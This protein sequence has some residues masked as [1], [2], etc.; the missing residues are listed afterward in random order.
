M[1]TFRRKV[2]PLLLIV[3]LAVTLMPNGIFAK[4]EDNAAVVEG[5]AAGAE[6]TE[7]KETGEAQTETPAETPVETSAETPAETPVEAAS[8]TP[9]EEKQVTP[10]AETPTETLTET[11][12]ETVTPAAETATETLTEETATEK[13]QTTTLTVQSVG[14][15]NGS[16]SN[17]VMYVDHVDIAKDDTANSVAVPNSAAVTVTLADGSTVNLSRTGTST[18]GHGNAQWRYTFSSGSGWYIANTTDTNAKRIVKVKVTYTVGTQGYTY[19]IDSYTGLLAGYTDCPGTAYATSNKGLDIAV[20]GSKNVDYYFYKVVYQYYKDGALEATDDTGTVSQVTATSVTLT[21][22]ASKVRQ[23]LTYTLTSAAAVYT[24]ISLTASKNDAA[25]FITITLKYSYTT[26]V[27]IDQTTY[28]VR[29]YLA[30]TGISAYEFEDTWA[31][32]NTLDTYAYLASDGVSSGTLIDANHTIPTAGAT[33]DAEVKA[34]LSTNKVGDLGTLETVKA[35][36]TALRTAGKITDATIVGKDSANNNITLGEF[37]DAADGVFSIAYVNV[38]NNGDILTTWK[39]GNKNTAGNYQL[40]YHVHAKIVRNTVDD[41]PAA[42]SFTILK[43]DA[44]GAAI[45]S[46]QAVFTLTKLNAQGAATTDVRTFTTSTTDGKVLVTL[47]SEAASYSLQETTAPAGYLVNSTV[48]KVTVTKGQVTV[49]LNQS[50]GLFHS[51]YSWIVNVLTGTPEADA[52]SGGVLTV[53]DAAKPQNNN[54]SITINKT[55][56]G[57]KGNKPTIS[58][59]ISDGTHTY[60]NYVTY[61]AADPAKASVTFNN[62]PAGTYTITE[63]YAEIT[64]YTLSTTGIPENGVTLTSTEG[65]TGYNVSSATVNVTNTYTYATDVK[66]LEFQKV[67]D[68]DSNRDG[69]RPYAIVVSGSVIAGNTETN[70]RLKA[71]AVSTAIP[72]ESQTFLTDYSTNSKVYGYKYDSILYQAGDIVLGEIGYYATKA[73]LDALK[74]TAVTPASATAEAP[75]VMSK[76][77]NAN[78]TTIFTN[79]HEPETLTFAAD[80]IWASGTARAVTLHLLADGKEVAQALVLNG[81]EQTAWGS[82][83]MAANGD[84]YVG[85]K[86]ANGKEITY[87]VTEDSLGSYWSSTVTEITANTTGANSFELGNIR[88]GVTVF[89]VTNSYNEPVIIIP[90]YY[91]VTVNYLNKTDGAILHTAYVTSAAAGSTYDVTAQDKLAI[92]GYTYDSTAGDATTGTL[93]SNKIVNVY[94]TATVEIPPVEPPTTEIPST[95]TPT[96]EIPDENTPTTSSPQTSDPMSIAG[97]LMTL[98]AAAGGILVFRKKKDDE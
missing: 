52:L 98:A 78:G 41:T 45:T 74:M 94:Y 39:A 25:K 36:L 83:F 38:T 37:L 47:D 70:G 33:G 12:V 13:K 84:P 8:E 6:Q 89:R 73:D 69:I 5:S 34:W 88:D 43:T 19:L 56:V 68:D 32:M 90:T 63:D 82:G 42:P 18:D 61:D 50:D 67:W 17:T 72:L 71:L 87:I 54:G 7:T 35:K 10:A 31:K 95:E 57:A 59:T 79:K 16:S 85:F 49:T 58:F 3:V 2:L 53:A 46:G 29:F 28:P 62:L 96:T 20:L 15:H 48:W 4:A 1:K 24:G 86:Y 27:V 51:V 60:G 81:S 22:D 23:T 93:L 30:G 80:K 9:T 26:P 66:E 97:A 75:Y 11:P 14:D 76:T 21:P 44:S 55:L 92:T 65:T 91:S 40:S 77:T 64:H